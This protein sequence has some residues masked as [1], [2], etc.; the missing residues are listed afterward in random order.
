MEAINSLAKN[1]FALLSVE[2]G[3]SIDELFNYLLTGY[4]P[5][6]KFTKTRLEISDLSVELNKRQIELHSNEEKPTEEQVTQ[7]ATR[8]TQQ[9]TSTL[10][11]EGRS[12]TH[13]EGASPIVE[14][15]GIIV[16]GT[17]YN[18]ES[19]LWLHDTVGYAVILN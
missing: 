19:I 1:T 2:L 18:R 13:W 16:T 3:Y 17:N 11:S 4:N 15:S 5:D 6:N 7:L 10:L 14:Q 9:L 12:V 8:I